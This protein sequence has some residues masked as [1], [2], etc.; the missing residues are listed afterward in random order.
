MM[1]IHLKDL[2]NTDFSDVADLGAPRIQHVHAGKVLQDEF[3]TPLN[4]SK[5]RLA[6][7]IGVSAPRIG[8]IVAG[9]RAITADTALRLSR[10]FGTTASFW[11]NLQASYDLEMTEYVIAGDL[12]HIHPYALP[13]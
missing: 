11:T 6:K 7:E 4:I 9:K 13:A 12:K 10:Y 2:A 1:T 5:Y 8:D 3:L